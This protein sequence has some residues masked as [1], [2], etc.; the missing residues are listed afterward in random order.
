[1]L[2]G[3]PR[4]FITALILA[5]VICRMRRE[6]TSATLLL[7]GSKASAVLTFR[8][9]GEHKRAE[10]VLRNSER[11]AVSGR[12][13]ATISHEINNPLESVSNLL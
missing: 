7:D 9:I 2:P 13:A 5:E 10:Q 6:Y 11:L 4:F 1:M 12:I 3:L 8:D